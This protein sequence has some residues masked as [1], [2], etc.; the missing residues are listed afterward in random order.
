ME[1]YNVAIIGGGASG[2]M[3][4]SQL[5]VTLKTV[6]LEAGERVGKKLL[7]TG[8]GRCNL[9]SVGTVTQAYNKSEFTD[10]VFELFGVRYTMDVFGGLGLKSRLIDGRVYPYSESSSAV[11]DVLRAALKRRVVT[12]LNNFKAVK[13]EKTDCFRVYSDNYS[14]TADYIVLAT[15][16]NAGFGTCSN[17]LLT[18]LGHHERPLK[19]SLVPV[20][21]DMSELRGLNG[22][23]VKCR[24]QLMRGQE[25]VA[26]QTGEV[27]FKDYGLS[28]IAIFNLAAHIARSGVEDG[29]VVELN[30]LPE[31]HDA[32]EYIE[33]RIAS[34]LFPSKDD[35]FTGVFHKN[36]GLAILNKA[37]VYGEVK[38][39]R[40]VFIGEAA[41]AFDVRVLGLCD[42]SLAQ[43]VSGGLDTAEFNPKT[44]ESG[45]VNNLYAVGE[46]LDVD[47]LCG[48]YNLQWAWSSALAVANDLTRKQF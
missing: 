34:G 3:L 2:L 17:G 25:V 4:A 13:I 36:L 33:E 29:Y 9:S 28:G 8:N 12:T 40:A 7:A 48:G 41:T 38:E 16:S 42:I 43:T 47:G 27:L 1:H 46:A 15:G 14:V 44:L 11:L 37:G 39:E 5:P 10:G 24:A 23:R 18:A 35:F 30:F 6:V 22:V 45:I 26:V 19:P 31:E 21:C 20:K 32:T